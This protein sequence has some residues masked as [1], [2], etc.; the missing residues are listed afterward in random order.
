M[1]EVNEKSQPENNVPQPAIEHTPPSEQI[2]NNVGVI[3]HSELESTLKDM[4]N[5]GGFFQT[6]EDLEQ[7]GCG[8]VILLK[9]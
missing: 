8:M 9:C 1:K 7:V 4:K 5:D 3:Y 6:N 2:E